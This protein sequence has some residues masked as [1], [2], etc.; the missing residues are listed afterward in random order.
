MPLKQVDEM[1]NNLDYL[2]LMVVFDS[3]KENSQNVFKHVFLPVL[4]ET[5]DYV[6]VFAYDCRD[7]EAISNRDRLE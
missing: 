3:E 2:A 6:K 7:Q 1:I 5:K 4:E